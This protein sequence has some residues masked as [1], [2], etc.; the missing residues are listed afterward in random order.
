MEIRDIWWNILPT[1]TSNK[2]ESSNPHRKNY[3]SFTSTRTVCLRPL[4]SRREAPQFMPTLPMKSLVFFSTVPNRLA[5]RARHLGLRMA[6]LV[7]T[8]YQLPR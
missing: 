7:R 2:V 3:L 8:I 1:L 5:S 4:E 6:V